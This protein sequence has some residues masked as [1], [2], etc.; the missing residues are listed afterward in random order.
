MEID[1]N[2]FI[3]Y[4][5]KWCEERSDYIKQCWPLR[6][7]WEAWVQIDFAAYMHSNYPDVDILREAEIF[8]MR[9]NS[10]G[11]RS[12][13]QPAVD[14]L[15]NGNTANPRYRI[16]VELKC[17]SAGPLVNSIGDPQQVDPLNISNQPL[18]PAIYSLVKGVNEDQEKL[19]QNNINDENRYCQTTVVALNFAPEAQNYLKNYTKLESIYITTN[20]EVEIWAQL[21]YT[22]VKSDWA[23]SASS[24]APFGLP[25]SSNS[26]G[27]FGS[28]LPGSSLSNPIDLTSGSSLLGSSASNPMEIE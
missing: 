26:S 11:N 7:S 4:L 8:K 9:L 24:T 12:S 22:S 5:K 2:T 10:K 6:G 19:N 27:L 25:V 28:P 16:A 23:N 20:R 18:Y 21:F 3:E 17:L 15:I 13:K 1:Y 14:W